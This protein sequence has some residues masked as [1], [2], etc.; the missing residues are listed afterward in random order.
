MK[1]LTA[2]IFATIVCLT[3]I[4]GVSASDTFQE[5]AYDPAL[6]PPY[7]AD[8]ET[9]AP[10]DV[11]NMM[12]AEWLA[13][14]YN[15]T[16]E[17]AYKMADDMITLANATLGTENKF[18]QMIITLKSNPVL[19]VAVF[20]SISAML[21][22]GVMFVKA[23]VK[24]GSTTDMLVTEYIEPSKNSFDSTQKSIEGMEST[25]KSYDSTIKKAADLAAQSDTQTAQIKTLTEQ[26]I[27]A[28]TQRK[29]AYTGYTKAME[30]NASM[31]NILMQNV[32]IPSGRK[33]EISELFT[34]AVR[35]IKAVAEVAH[36]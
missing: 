2:F 36:E 27:I 7:D 8:F 32:N 19:L 17:E 1:K 20:I 16:L 34:K 3:L 14:K 26:N 9:A 4:I 28:E 6:D 33:D 30:L 5:S 11:D 15:V 24:N 21:G 22:A 10:S 31:L 13:D 23:N 35:E 29:A 18:T 25:L 12:V